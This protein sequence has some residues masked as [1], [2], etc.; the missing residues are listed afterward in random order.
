[1]TGSNLKSDLHRYLQAGRDAMLWTLDGLAEYGI[2]RPLTPTGT[3]LL[4]LIK[5]LAGV[6]LGY[7]G[8]TFG[9]P[10]DDPPP[11]LRMLPNPTWT[12]G[13]RPPS[14]ATR[15]SGSTA[16]CGSTRT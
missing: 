2:R 5:Y 6:D 13:R 14:R 4:G 12:C 15:S 1:M 3:N 11:G 8:Y 16:E 9:R 10:F 7:F